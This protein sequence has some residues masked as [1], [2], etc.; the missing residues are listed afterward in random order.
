M[1][2][3]RKKF[4]SVLIEIRTEVVMFEEK[5]VPLLIEMPI[6]IMHFSRKKFLCVLIE[7]RTQAVK[8]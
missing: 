1:N 6:G 4:L 2:V 5:F 7:I 8:V 3:S